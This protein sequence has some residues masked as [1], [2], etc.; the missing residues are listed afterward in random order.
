MLFFPP[1]L[2]GNILEINLIDGVLA[3]VMFSVMAS[4]T[5]IVND[6]VDCR[7]D[8]HHPKKKFRPLPAGLIT[9]VNASVLAVVLCVAALVCSFLWVQSITVWLLIYGVLSVVYSLFLK[10]IFFVDLI[11]I[12]SF[13]IIRLYAGGAVFQ[14]NI[15][16]WLLLSVL[17]L[18]LLLSAGKR[19]SELY[20]LGENAAKH[21][22]SLAK[23][24]AKKLNYILYVTA[25]L[26]LATYTMYCVQHKTLLYSVPLCTYGL[27]RYIYRIKHGGDGDPTASLLRDWQMLVVAVVWVVM[28]G[29][30]VYMINN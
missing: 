11:A 26:V 19:L 22:S 21:R 25:L 29:L 7:A 12:S 27:V 24:S 10:D 14:V 6:V 5:Y 20:V 4:A 1:F 13:F 16:V 2:A 30:N 8:R 17:L 15:S 9:A 28:V 3:F 23:Y 18:S